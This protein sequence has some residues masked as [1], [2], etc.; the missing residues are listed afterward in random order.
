I[1]G[2]LDFSPQLAK[3]LFEPELLAQLADFSLQYRE[4]TPN[5]PKHFASLPAHV[6]GGFHETSFDTIVDPLLP[7]RRRGCDRGCAPIIAGGNAGVVPSFVDQV[8]SRRRSPIMRRSPITVLF[9]VRAG[10]SQ[11]SLSSRC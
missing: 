7:R 4:L 6:L 3:A 8:Q 11:N 5:L 9:D 10:L 1:F 2:A